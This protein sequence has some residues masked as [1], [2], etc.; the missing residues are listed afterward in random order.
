MR[1]TDR[2]QEKNDIFKLIAIHRCLAWPAV[3][4][5]LV[6]FFLVPVSE[7]DIYTYVDENG[8]RHFSNVP[9]SGQY[10]LYVRSTPKRRTKFRSTKKFDRY[11]TKAS[12]RHGVE[13]NLVK[14]VI[15]AESD[16]DPKAVS[17]KGAKGLMQIM[18]ENYKLLSIQNP[19]NPDQNIMGGTKYLKQLMKK[20]DGELSL[21][22]AAYNA[23]PK[24]VEKYNGIPPYRETR[25]YVRKVLQFYRL[26]QKKG[27]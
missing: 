21:T 27:S 3:V 4:C 6:S 18:P 7:A 24:A 23:G 25:N 5:L 10:K 16:F 19:F 2:K 8:V 22:L 17:R 13:F 14:A 26:Y 11:I 20:F 12:R 1:L 9:T 15:K